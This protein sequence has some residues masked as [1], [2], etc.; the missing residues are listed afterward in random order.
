[1]EETESFSVRPENGS[2]ILFI[3]RNFPFLVSLL[4]IRGNSDAAGSLFFLSAHVFFWKWHSVR[5]WRFSGTVMM[6]PLENAIPVHC[7]KHIYMYIWKAS[8]HPC[9]RTGLTDFFEVDSNEQF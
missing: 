1:M 3:G 8:G 5:F 4:F 2:C 9:A 6:Y 7:I